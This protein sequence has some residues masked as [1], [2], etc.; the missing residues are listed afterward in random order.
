MANNF[1]KLVDSRKIKYCHFKYSH[2]SHFVSLWNLSPRASVPFF[3][4]L[5]TAWLLWYS[6]RNRTK[7]MWMRWVAHVVRTWEVRVS[8][9]VGLRHFLKGLG[10]ILGPEAGYDARIFFVI[11]LVAR[12]KFRAASNLTKTASFWS[13]SVNCRVIVLSLDCM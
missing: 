1:L 10:W 13:I 5:I 7:L 4:L 2:F 9:L 8:R 6:C 3:Q 12:G 11:L